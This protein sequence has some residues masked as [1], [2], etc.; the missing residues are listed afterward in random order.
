MFRGGGGDHYR[1]DYVMAAQEE[2]VGK[3]VRERLEVPE[4][5]VG[6][7]VRAHNNTLDV[8]R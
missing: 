5:Q 6:E 8:F 7:G 3:D 4:E 2:M 1:G